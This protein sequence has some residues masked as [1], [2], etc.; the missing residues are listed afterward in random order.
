MHLLLYKEN[1]RT[2][3]VSE[4]HAPVKTARSARE[5]TDMVTKTTIRRTERGSMKLTRR[6][7][8]GKL[9]VGSI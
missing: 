6:L 5:K 4:R 2:H 3:T 7:V 8:V 1:E 9:E